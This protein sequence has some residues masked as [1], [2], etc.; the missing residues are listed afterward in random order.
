MKIKVITMCILCF[1]ILS[2]C[3]AGCESAADL[4]GDQITVDTDNDGDTDITINVGSLAKWGTARFN[5]HR[6]SQ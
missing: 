6:W 4:N 1:A 3:F 2:I 5:E